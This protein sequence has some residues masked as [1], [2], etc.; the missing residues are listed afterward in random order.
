MGYDVAHTAVQIGIRGN[1]KHPDKLTWEH[2]QDVR[3]NEGKKPERENFN[4]LTFKKER[5]KG[6]KKKTKITYL[7]KMKQRKYKPKD[8]LEGY[9][10][11]CRKCW[12]SCT[13]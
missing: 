9:R 3:L 2:F 12:L 5:R 4:R 8:N 13:Q 7:Q 1:E 10:S 6:E 11:H